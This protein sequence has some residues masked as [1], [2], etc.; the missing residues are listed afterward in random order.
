MLVQGFDRM[1]SGA[2]AVAAAGQAFVRKGFD[3]REALPGPQEVLTHGSGCGV[4]YLAATGNAN[5]AGGA[6]A[7]I[8]RWAARCGEFLTVR[9]PSR[10]SKSSWHIVGASRLHGGIASQ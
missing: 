5:C 2:R 9:W 3:L 8:W 10:R 7:V 6:D 4:G 1:V